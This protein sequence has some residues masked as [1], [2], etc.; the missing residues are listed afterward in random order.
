ML[1]SV[2][3][4]IEIAGIAA[5]LPTRIVETESYKPIFGNETVEKFMSMTGVKSVHRASEMQT[6]SDLGYEAAVRLIRELEISES[7]VGVLIFVTQ[8]PDCR[9]PSTSFILHRRLRLNKDC[10]CFDINLACSGYIYGIM[11]A[12]ALLSSS[13]ASFGLLITG[14]TSVRTLSPV[15]RS[16]IM[17]FGDAGTATLI[18]KKEDTAP[19]YISVKT[20]GQRFKS[21][22]TPSGAYRN[23]GAPLERVEWGDDIVRSD[24]DTHMKGMDVF[25]FSIT[26]VPS[27]LKEMMNEIHTTVEDYDYFA[28]HQ[29]N[30]YI[31]QQISRQ[32][33]IPKEKVPVSI[34]RFG[35]TSSNSVP[36][37]LSDHFGNMNSGSARIMFAGFGAG[38]SWACAD[39]NLDLSNILPVMYTDN[40]YEE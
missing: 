26:D 27:L 31:I 35:N 24:Y 7:D 9:V 4:S 15:D 20:D 28:L 13:E 37:L 32:L 18:R 34:G 12:L 8:K 29:A 36:L 22:I 10:T 19:V 6:A 21:I 11:T 23:T 14:D 3:D 17:L 2:F 25:A 30:L 33:K 16:M 1:L 38:L 39:M 40:Y 5:A